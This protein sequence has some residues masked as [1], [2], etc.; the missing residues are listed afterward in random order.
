MLAIQKYKDEDIQNCNCACCFIWVLNLVAHI[1]E[2]Q[3]ADEDI[4]A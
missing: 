3:G 4:W 2:E 1:E